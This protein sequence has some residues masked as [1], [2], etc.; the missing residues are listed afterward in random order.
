MGSGLFVGY[1]NVNNSNQ[2]DYL[3]RVID[4]GCVLIP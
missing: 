1:S 4:D 3:P 2:L